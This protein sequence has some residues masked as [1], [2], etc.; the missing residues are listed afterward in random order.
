MGKVGTGKSGQWAWPT[1]TTCWTTDRLTD[2][3]FSTVAVIDEAA[4]GCGKLRPRSSSAVSPGIVH[5]LLV[6]TCVFS[7]REL[8][9]EPGCANPVDAR[10]RGVSERH[11][12]AA[13]TGPTRAGSPSPKHTSTRMNDLLRPQRVELW[14]RRGHASARPGDKKLAAARL[15][16]RVT[17]TAARSA[18]IRRVAGAGAQQVKVT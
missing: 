14:D 1:V 4:D 11:V 9:N 18:V 15:S 3:Q 13:S 5:F 8:R 2:V 10:P 16:G 6:H 12:H 17:Q 7:R